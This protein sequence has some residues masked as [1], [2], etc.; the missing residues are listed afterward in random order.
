MNQ[1]KSCQ[2]EK[3]RQ[4][5]N[6]PFFLL[7]GKPVISRMMDTFFILLMYFIII[8]SHVS[9]QIHENLDKKKDFFVFQKL[10]LNLSDSVQLFGKMNRRI[11]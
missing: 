4:K 10:F 2:R 1:K 3:H 8:I 5:I 11:E 9:L 7:S 6:E